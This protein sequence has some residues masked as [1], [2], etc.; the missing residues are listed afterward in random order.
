MAGPS[1]DRYTVCPD[2]GHRKVVAVSDSYRCIFRRCD[3]YFFAD[4]VH[5]EDRRAAARWRAAN[6]PTMV[7]S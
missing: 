3:F 7:P 1:A 6:A 4:E 5:G 2:C